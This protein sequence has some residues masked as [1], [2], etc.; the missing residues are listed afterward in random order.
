M[1]AN[2]IIIRPIITEK[3]MKGAQQNIYSF[4]VAR[5]ATKKDIQHAVE[6]LFDVKVIGIATQTQK[7]GGVRSGMKR[8]EVK[9]QP[10]K[11]AFV[12]VQKGQKISAFELAA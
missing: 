8:T 5:L 12:R 10:T 11:K 3:S 9:K 4:F 6:T 7:G 1:R 2:D